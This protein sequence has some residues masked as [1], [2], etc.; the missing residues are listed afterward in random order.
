MVI[1]FKD[2]DIERLLEKKAGKG[3]PS[4]TAKRDLERYYVLISQAQFDHDFTDNEMAL[5]YD[6]CNGVAFEAI[7][8]DPGIQHNVQDAIVQSKLDVKHGVD[9]EALRQKLKALS[10][11]ARWAL[12]EKIEQ[13]WNS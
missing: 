10:P 13:F 7:T 1:S 3:S 11:I 5:I 8:A 12:V 4:L 6:A 2:I 9:G